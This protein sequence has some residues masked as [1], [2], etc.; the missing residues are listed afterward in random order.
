MATPCEEVTVTQHGTRVPGDDGS[1]DHDGIKCSHG[2][3]NYLI[4]VSE[5]GP[6]RARR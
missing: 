2:D 3:D 5:L 1:V 6:L 4:V